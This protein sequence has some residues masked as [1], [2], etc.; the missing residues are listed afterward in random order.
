MHM[1]TVLKHSETKIFLIWKYFV[2][3]GYKIC[4]FILTSAIYFLCLF[5]HAINIERTHIMLGNQ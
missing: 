2:A 4:G 5:N 3:M 1:E